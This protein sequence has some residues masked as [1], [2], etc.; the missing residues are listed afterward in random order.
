MKHFNPLNLKVARVRA[1]LTLEQVAPSIGRA[2]Q[3]VSNWETGVTR[4]NADALAGLAHLYRCSI[5]DFYDD[6]PVAAAV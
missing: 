2:Q 4:P 1:Q 6:E 3:T 5:T